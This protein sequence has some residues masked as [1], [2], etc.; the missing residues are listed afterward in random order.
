MPFREQERGH[1]ENLKALAKY[2]VPLVL[3]R[4]MYV[5]ELI[6]RLSRLPKKNY[7]A[8]KLRV[9]NFEDEPY[10]VC[11]GTGLWVASSPE[12]HEAAHP[13]HI[14]YVEDLRVDEVS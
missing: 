5:I 2:F 11:V 3:I 8:A 6:V 14:V 7:P 12:L 1:A 9:D 4:V 13:G 10:R